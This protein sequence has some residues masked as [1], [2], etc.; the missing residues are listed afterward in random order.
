MAFVEEIEIK[1]L[2]G[3]KNISWKNLN[4]D[5]N[6]IV[7]INGSGK[8]I[9][10]NLIWGYISQNN[11]ILKRYVYSEFL[12]KYSEYDISES[13]KAHL[14][15]EFISTFDVLF[16]HNKKGESLL[17]L[18]LLDVIYTTGQSKNTF[19]DYRLKAT[20]FPDQ[21]DSIN[22]RIQSFYRLIDRQFQSTNKKIEVD[23]TS[24]KLIFKQG[25]EIIQIEDLSSG[26]KQFLLIMFKVFL[27]EEKPYILLMDEPEISMHIDWQFELI[28]II[29]ELNSNCQI[30]IST[31]SPGMF[32]DVWGDKVIY[33]EDITS[34]E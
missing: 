8:T 19:F 14:N 16:S 5:V 1:G 34:Y 9:L 18:D 2:W 31:H 13:S 26:E 23:L 6:I 12:C 25:E 32:G 21:A 20:N 4:K 11:K 30:I 3:K 17:T 28:N 7:G 10:L 15:V 22:K 33:M 29:R 27:M 24:N